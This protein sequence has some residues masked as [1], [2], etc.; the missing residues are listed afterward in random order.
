MLMA[1][2]Y[3]LHDIIKWEDNICN[4]VGV[5]GPEDY[6]EVSSQQSSRGAFGRGRN[7]R[8]LRERREKERLV[9]CVF[10]IP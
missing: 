6:S 9:S 2:S 8:F 10:F 1:T 3:N 7:L 5:I 4:I